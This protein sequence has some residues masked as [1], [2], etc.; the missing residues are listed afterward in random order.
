MT[1][2]VLKRFRSG[3][4]CLL[5]SGMI[6]L[7]R[8]PVP[9]AA[10]A[11]TADAGKVFERMAA[12]IAAV[13]DYQTKWMYYSSSPGPSPIWVRTMAE[14]KFVH[15]PVR[16]Y[17][18][19]LSN[20]NNFNDPVKPG[21]QMIFDGKNNEN[22]VLLPGLMQMLG[23]IHLFAEDVKCMDL[24]GQPRTI[25]AIWDQVEDWKAKLKTGNAALRAEQYQGANFSVLTIT[26]PTTS[27]GGKTKINRI[28]IW[29]DPA[30]NLPRRYRGF[31]PENSKPVAEVEYSELK[32]NPGLKAAALNFEGLSLWK[33][34]A[35]FV[36]NAEGLDQL[37]YE[38]PTKDPGA[39][40]AIEQVQQRLEAALAPIK[41]YRAEYMFT[42]KYFRLRSKGRV[43]QSVIR[44]P[45]AF[46]FEFAPD[47]RI[48]HL[49][50]LSSGGKVCLR[51]DARTYAAMGS[52]AMRAA[53]A[54][55]MHVDDTR[56][57]F[58]CGES[59][60]NMNLFELVPRLKW[61][62]Q[63]GKVSVDLV[64]IGSLICPRII[65]E[66]TTPPQPGELQKLTVALNPE[67]G[68][69]LRVEYLD[70]LDPQGYTVIEYQSLK[71]N[72]GLKE[73]ALKF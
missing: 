52:G 47:F 66:R 25:D 71:T 64:K 20:E 30:T 33:F 8:G 72:L 3:A 11:D 19:V 53:G 36:A 17:E 51:R 28:E 63:N 32:V 7:V 39:P 48:N 41:D 15:S 37:K 34:P 59:F 45:R 24:N 57:N 68:L 4:I 61:Y 43:T 70:N 62:R 55:V 73:E 35:Q 18:K 23:V 2:T 9:E 42:Q 49:H 69:P 38:P 6:L 26:F 58:P 10:M 16:Y 12:A 67:T 27:L 40:P 44:E 14:G 65:M 56:S 29:V 22:L 1:T 46:L 31:V 5:V 21:T 54:Q 60:Y 50:M 13:S